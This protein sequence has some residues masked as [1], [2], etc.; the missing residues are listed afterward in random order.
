MEILTVCIAELPYIQW[1]SC[2]PAHTVVATT[3]EGRIGALQTLYDSRILIWYD[4]D[5][6]YQFHSSFDIIVWV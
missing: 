6:K 3:L 1:I 4:N 2:K 5:I